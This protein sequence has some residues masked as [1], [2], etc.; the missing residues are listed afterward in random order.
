M[1]AIGKERETGGSVDS[2]GLRFEMCALLVGLAGIRFLSVLHRDGTGQL[3]TLYASA[4]WF[5]DVLQRVMGRLVLTG[6]V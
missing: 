3:S 6:T 1:S 2:G 5:S 4:Y